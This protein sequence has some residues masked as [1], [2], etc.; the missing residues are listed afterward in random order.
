MEDKKGWLDVLKELFSKP[1]IPTVA[2]ALGLV[3]MVLIGLSSLPK[4]DSAVSSPSEDTATY[5]EELEERLEIMVSSVR[6]AGASRVM[7]T[8]ENG[9]E[10]VYA[11]EE[12]INS[13]H[14]QGD[15]GNVSVRDDSQKTVVTVDADSGKQ[16]LL[17]TEI[18]PTVRG[19]VVACEGAQDEAVAALV[20]T[21]VKTALNVTDKRVCVIPYDSKGETTT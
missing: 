18:Q 9:V 8:L 5:V 3:G 15:S 11:S 19:V 16:G 10:Y 21:A 2:M 20:K 6:G 1:R 14:T 13:D 12:K 4:K 7:V 17:V